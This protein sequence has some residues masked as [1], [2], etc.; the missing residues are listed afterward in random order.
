MSVPGYSYE[1]VGAGSS[2]PTAKT[3]GKA[4]PIGRDLLLD[5]HVYDLVVKGGDLGLVHDVDAIVQEVNI[6]LRFFLAEW[7]LDKTAG[8]PY[9]QEIVVKSPVL[10]AV[11]SV[12]R[13]EIL[14][15]AGIDSVTSLE[16][17]LDQSTRQ[18]TVTWAGTTNLGALIPTQEVT[19]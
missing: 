4:Q 19:L 16:L 15:C 7:F 13:D 18:L 8:V 12:L 17:E 9:L 3:L 11:K 2:L 14:N 1:L 10:A 5:T 6:R